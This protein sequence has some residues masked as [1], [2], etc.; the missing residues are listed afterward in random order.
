MIGRSQQRDR[1]RMGDQR[2]S[3]AFQ[4][5]G[6]ATIDGTRDDFQSV[7]IRSGRSQQLFS[8]YTS[9]N[10]FQYSQTTMK[11]LVLLHHP[12]G[13]LRSV[14]SRRTENRSNTACSFVC[15]PVIDKRP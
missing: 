15:T 3:E 10:L 14:V 5:L 8:L 9:S 6:I 1:L 11:F 12:R 13:K 7:P 4:G 2:E